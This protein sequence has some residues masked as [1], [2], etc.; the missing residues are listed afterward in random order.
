MVKTRC[1]VI[2]RHQPPFC[3]CRKP[4]LFGNLRQK[5]G[6]LLMTRQRPFRFPGKGRTKTLGLPSSPST[7]NLVLP[8]HLSSGE[9]GWPRLGYRPEETPVLSR[10]TGGS[11][12]TSADRKFRF[13]PNFIS[14]VNLRGLLLHPRGDS[15]GTTSSLTLFSSESSSDTPPQR[16]ELREGRTSSPV[17]T[18]SCHVSRTSPQVPDLSGT[19]RD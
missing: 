12:R 7:W 17:F 19:P 2:I 13:T 10:T 1:C 4:S 3:I 6:T 14:G 18:E 11:H 15:S 8:A 16:R 5:A 9:Q